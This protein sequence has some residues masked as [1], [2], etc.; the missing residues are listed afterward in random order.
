MYL[1][2][3]VFLNKKIM[4]KQI[5]FIIY[6]IVSFSNIQSQVSQE[7]VRRY[8]EQTN[9]FYNIAG[10][11]TDKTGNVYVSGSIQ[12]ATLTDYLTVKYSSDGTLQWAKVY[13]GLIEDR[14]I[15]MALDTSGNVYVTGLSENTTGTYDIITIKYDQNGDSLWVKRYNGAH[16][17]TMD[18]PTAMFIDRNNFVYVCGY[19]FGSSPSEYVII[20]YN[21]NQVV[22]IKLP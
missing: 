6:L 12:G 14:V 20:K 18:Q 5:F 19:S 11:K 7:W 15:D 13:T 9:G 8:G 16:A 2:E 17:F 1:L 3:V 4:T 22:L 21:S 10:I